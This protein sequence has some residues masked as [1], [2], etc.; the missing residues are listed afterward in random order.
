[1]GSTIAVTLSAN[2]DSVAN[3][4]AQPT[5]SLAK[6]GNGSVKVEG[7]LRSLPWSGSF[8]SGTLVALEAVPDA[9]WVFDGWSGD[10]TW[11]GS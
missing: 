6:T 4:S 9:G 1:M 5:L 8:L 10:A 2:K 11:S 3:F 7:A